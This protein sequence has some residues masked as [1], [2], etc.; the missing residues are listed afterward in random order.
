MPGR[1]SLIADGIRSAVQEILGV[2]DERLEIAGD[3]CPGLA[4]RAKRVREAIPARGS[5][6]SS[7]A[8][9]YCCHVACLRLG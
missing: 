3:R 7:T 5:S 2:I 8:C 1:P 6:V 4:G 9:C